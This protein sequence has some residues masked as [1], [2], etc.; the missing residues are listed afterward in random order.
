MQKHNIKLCYLALML[1]ISDFVLIFKR[2]KKK[3]QTFQLV[4]V[5]RNQ[6]YINFFKILVGFYLDSICWMYG[7]CFLGWPFEMIS[8]NFSNHVRNTETTSNVTSP[9]KG[10]QI[11]LDDLSLW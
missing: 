3:W 2:S 11:S 5:L 10:K 1:L 4:L 9:F 7:Q 6:G 8:S